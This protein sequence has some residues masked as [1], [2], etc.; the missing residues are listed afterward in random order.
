MDGKSREN[1]H[2]KTTELPTL[3]GD[4]I[5]T[6][7]GREL[8]LKIYD[9]VCQTWRE[10]VAV[11]FRLLAIVPSVSLLLLAAVLSSE[12]PGKGL[13]IGLKLLLSTLGSVVTAG[14]LIYDLRNSQFHDDLISRARKIEAELGVDTGIF[15]GRLKAGRVIKHD[16][17]T[18]L[19]Y[20]A[21]L[22]GWLA[23]LTHLGVALFAGGW[24]CSH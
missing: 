20:G 3:R 9:Q 18:G 5:G 2:Y 13:P 4:I 7:P 6:E 17:A 24:P 8:L 21:S 12:G 23:A 14:L 22:V 15:L 10:L 19:I 1:R 11:R 16:V